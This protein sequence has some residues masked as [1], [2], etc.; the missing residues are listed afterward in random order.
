M[1]DKILL[2]GAGLVA[3]GAASYGLLATFVK[4]AYAENYTTAEVTASQM[5]LGL[6]GIA[7]VYFMQITKVQRV[8]SLT[9]K[10][11]IGL[12]LSGT[13]IGF[14]SVFYYLSLSYVPVPVGIVLLMQSV[15]M[16]IAA[17]S[18][19]A[20]TLPNGRKLFAALVVICGTVLAVNLLDAKDLLDWRGVAWG[21]GA[22]I[23]YTVTMYAGHRIAPHLMASQRTYYML[24]G[25]A[26][27]AGVFLALTWPGH[28]SYSILL[29]WGIPLA[30]FG[31]VLPP[32]LMNAGFPKINL[33]LGTIISSLELPVSV[34]T[35]WAV[36]HE[37]V[38]PIQWLGIGLIIG[39]VVL[40]N[41][42]YGKKG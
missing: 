20:K 40:M 4:L 26:V 33:G 23:S 16:G 27:V 42:K 1:S 13:S 17:E 11:R 21:I 32:L 29:R 38:R 6:L 18:L 9:N 2:K 41:A 7:V 34:V 5:G 10:D 19:A 28:F 8:V 36:L 35:A 22:A 24:V 30:L 31:T 39:A 15:W 25:G 3:L 37:E 12:V 14:T